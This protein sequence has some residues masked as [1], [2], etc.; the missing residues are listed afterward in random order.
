MNGLHNDQGLRVFECAAR[1]GSFARAA[2]EL[3]MTRAAVSA[4]VRGLEARLGLPLFERHATR[5]RL[6]PAA[7]ALAGRLAQAYLQVDDAL[8]GLRSGGERPVITVSAVPNLAT[9]WLMPRLSGWLQQ[10][11][12]LDLQLGS[13]TSLSPLGLDGVDLALRDG[14]GD[15]PGLKAWRLWPMVLAPLARPGRAGKDWMMR[16][17]LFG[18]QRR[19]WLMWMRAEGLDEALLERCRLV[20]WDCWRLVADAAQQGAGVA[21]LPAALHDLELTEGRLRRLGSAVLPLP[22]AHWLVVRPERLR[23]RPVRTLVDWLRAEAA[24]TEQRLAPLLAD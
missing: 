20:V 21:L 15:W 23:Q 24:A 5:V 3:G 18:L 14:Y 1:H 2:D 16:Q 7:A 4:Q 12:E 6:T 19:D 17:A 13:S 11:P 9:A 22:R 8:R 10:H